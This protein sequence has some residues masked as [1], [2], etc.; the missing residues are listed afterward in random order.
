MD[1]FEFVIDEVL[2]EKLRAKAD[3]EAEALKAGVREV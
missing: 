1:R 3:A 2:V